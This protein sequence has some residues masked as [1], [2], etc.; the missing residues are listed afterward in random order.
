MLG[1]WRQ[2][3]SVFPAFWQSLPSEACRGARHASSAAEVAKTLYI[4]NTEGRRS[5][6]PIIL[7]LFEHFERL[8]GP[9]VGFFQVYTLS[10]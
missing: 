1:L 10:V 2:S 3:R 9:H 7:G 5:A 8:L 6:S 4:I